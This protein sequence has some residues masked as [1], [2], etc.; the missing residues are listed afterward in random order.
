MIAKFL[1]LGFLLI[2]LLSACASNQRW[3]STKQVAD[4]TEQLQIGD[5]LITPKIWYEPI[6]WY[7]HSAILVTPNEIGEYPKFGAGYQQVDLLTW[8]YARDQVKVLR[9]AK[10]D[11]AFIKQLKIN[12]DAMRNKSYLITWDKNY[13]Q[14]FYCSSYVW[15]AFAK[16]ARDLGYQ[17]D[18]DSDQGILVLPYDILK[19]QHLQPITWQ[20]QSDRIIPVQVSPIAH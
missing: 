9:Y 8:L 16:T 10:A 17:L 19:S 4:Q 12:L 14:G 7:G 3:L 6:S 20:T 18:I 13:S 11:D 5:V 15:Y 1:S 2:A